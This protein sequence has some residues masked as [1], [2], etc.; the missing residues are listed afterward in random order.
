MVHT[1][2]LPTK[3]LTIT[4]IIAD[5]TTTLTWHTN[6]IVASRKLLNNSNKIQIWLK[7]WNLHADF[8]KSILPINKHGSRTDLKGVSVQVANSNRKYEVVFQEYY[9]VEGVS[10]TK[11]ISGSQTDDLIAPTAYQRENNEYKK[12]WNPESTI[13]PV[14]SPPV[15]FSLAPTC[16]I[17]VTERNWRMEHSH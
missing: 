12:S 9:V 16:R 5:D 13:P 15:Q 14:Q 8:I 1:P 2:H 3:R 17:K 7:V 11:Q 10:L 4:A 6:L